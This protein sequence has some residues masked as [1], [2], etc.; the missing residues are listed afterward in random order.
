M[1]QCQDIGVRTLRQLV[2]IYH[3]ND[4]AMS[5]FL[6]RAVEVVRLYIEESFVR[7]LQHAETAMRKRAYCSLMLTMKH[8]EASAFP[9]EHQEMGIFVTFDE[10]AV[11]VMAVSRHVQT[12]PL[13]MLPSYDK[14]MMSPDLRVEAFSL[15]RT[16]MPREMIFMSNDEMRQ[17]NADRGHEAPGDAELPGFEGPGVFADM[18]QESDED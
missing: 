8:F 14:V 15:M 5:V 13:R 18:F 1:R 2:R 9:E 10:H 6:K 16:R 17:L 11:R 7:C 12:R 4:E 3:S